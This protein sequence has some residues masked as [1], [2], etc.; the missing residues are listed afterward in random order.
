[1]HHLLVRLLRLLR[2]SAVV[3]ALAAQAPSPVVQQ[4]R[5]LPAPSKPEL[6]LAD[7]R[8]VLESQRLT[9][10]RR[11]EMYMTVAGRQYLDSQEEQQR[12]YEQMC[13]KYGCVGCD[14]RWDMKW[15]APEGAMFEPRKT[16]D[17]KK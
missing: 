7:A 13:Q 15:Y 3:F 12:V 10:H 17:A 4:L 11:A 6:D 1:M 9:E 14:L 8:K 5:L 2:G 16:D